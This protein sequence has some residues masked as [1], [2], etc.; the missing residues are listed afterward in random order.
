MRW[1]SAVLVATAV[2]A[3]AAHTAC[4]EPINAQDGALY[5]GLSDGLEQTYTRSDGLSETHSYERIS[6]DESGEEIF[7]RMAIYAGGFVVDDRTMTVEATATDLRITRLH[8]CVTRCG[9]LNTPLVLFTWPIEANSTHTSQAT[10][11]LLVN[12]EDQ[13]SH[14]ED[15]R[16]AFGGEEERSV[17]GTTY[18]GYDAVWTR[19]KTT[20][21]DDDTATARLFFVPEVGFVSIEGF[22]DGVTLELD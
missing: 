22:D 4:I 7:E 21:G 15:H 3:L 5:L 13:G 10:V 11:D 19:T 18:T 8:D 14:D 2:V 1:S 6:D 9:E 16:I 12:N 17:N 20:D